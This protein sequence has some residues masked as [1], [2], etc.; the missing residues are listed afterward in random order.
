[1]YHSAFTGVLDFDRVSEIPAWSWFDSKCPDWF[2]IEFHSVSC[3][4]YVARHGGEAEV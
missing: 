1:M 4:E 3:A 2:D